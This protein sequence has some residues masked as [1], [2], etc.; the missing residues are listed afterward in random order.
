MFNKT[1]HSSL[2][3]FEKF[4]LVSIFWPHEVPGKNLKGWKLQNERHNI[5]Q[6]GKCFTCKHCHWNCDH[7]L[8][9]H[10]SQSWWAQSHLQ[11][12]HSGDCPTCNTV[13]RAVSKGLSSIFT[14]HLSAPKRKGGSMGVWRA[15]GVN[16]GF[17]FKNSAALQCELQTLL[18]RDWRSQHI[19]IGHVWA[20]WEKLTAKKPCNQK[21]THF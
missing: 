1:Q 19:N 7:W 5:E 14:L 8:K 10:S 4:T 21:F 18:Q 3:D 2:G 13:S 9:A 12:I 15:S 11:I 20:G 6:T 17:L 16:T